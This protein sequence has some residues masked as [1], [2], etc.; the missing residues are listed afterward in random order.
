[1]EEKPNGSDVLVIGQ[2]QWS[3]EIWEAGVTKLSFVLTLMRFKRRINNLKTSCVIVVEALPIFLLC[4]DH[5]GIFYSLGL[6]SLLSLGLPCWLDNIAQ[7][8]ACNGNNCANIVH[9]LVGCQRF[10]EAQYLQ[11]TKSNSIL[12]V[13]ILAEEVIQT[14][15]PHPGWWSRRKLS[16]LRH[17]GSETILKSRII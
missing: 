14:S 5:L 11:K 8:Q 2:L 4:N 13:M 10:L 15:I 3:S 17:V 12:M 6:L 9:A 7:Q 1:M 16:S